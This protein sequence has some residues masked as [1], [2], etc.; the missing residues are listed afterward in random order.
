MW[1]IHFRKQNDRTTCTCFPLFTEH[2]CACRHHTTSQCS[3]RFSAKY[4]VDHVTYVSAG[5]GGTIKSSRYMEDAFSCRYMRSVYFLST[6]VTFTV[7]WPSSY[8]SINKLRHVLGSVLLGGGAPPTIHFPTGLIPLLG[9]NTQQ[10]TPTRRSSCV[11]QSQA[12]SFSQH[13]K[14]YSGARRVPRMLKRK[15][16]SPNQ[17]LRGS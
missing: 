8:N 9:C 10:R 3:S 1:H 7:C 14:V 15:N 17:E 4:T 5:R 6:F 2:V 12:C 13:K 16:K 11:N